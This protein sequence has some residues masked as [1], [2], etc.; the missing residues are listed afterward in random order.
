MAINPCLDPESATYQALNAQPYKRLLD[1]LERA[2]RDHEYFQTEST[3]NYLE[4]V[5]WFVNLRRARGYLLSTWM[6]RSN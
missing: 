1:E 2:K 5:E 6:E 4:A 3:K